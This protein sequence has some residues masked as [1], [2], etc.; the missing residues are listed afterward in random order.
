[1]AQEILTV[2]PKFKTEVIRTKETL[3]AV[4][5]VTVLKRR[6]WATA[7]NPISFILTIPGSV[8]M[9]TCIVDGV[10]PNE[11][12]ILSYL[13]FGTLGTGIKDSELQ[14]SNVAA[15]ILSSLVSYHYVRYLCGYIFLHVQ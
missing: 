1:M 2:R 8:F 12:S 10:V 15:S 14:T 4:F 11:L 7:K 5:L 6:L 13:V 3:A 9:W